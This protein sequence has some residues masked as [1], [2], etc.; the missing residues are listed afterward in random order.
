MDALIVGRT[1]AAHAAAWKLAESRR[2]G[3]L[4]CTSPYSGID[5]LCTFVGED[6][7]PWLKSHA[8]S[9]ILETEGETLFEADPVSS[10]N[11]IHIVVDC[12]SDGHTIVPL[13]AVRMYCD[14]NGTAFAAEAPADCFPDDLLHYAYHHFF[15]PHIR[16]GGHTHRGRAGILRFEM[17]V[18]AGKPVLLSAR[19]GMGALDAA[20]VLPL[21][22][23]ELAALLLACQAG[24]LTRE[25]VRLNGLA[26]SVLA[27]DAAQ[28]DV[29]IRG[30]GEVPSNVGVFM[31]TVR[32][33][34]GGMYTAGAH[35]LLVC[36]RS[37]TVKEA[38]NCAKAGASRIRFEGMIR[39]L[40]EELK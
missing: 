21:L 23:G 24:T 40:P 35:P 29:H 31:G 14:E 39:H 9:L 11:Q 32:F 22:R 16:T 2:I 27:L 36:S 6:P 34:D 20:A 25:M 1:A 13:P 26:M 3:A 33:K 28:K 38:R 5:T 17:G 10:D 19:S 8:P 7:E 18:S 30:L 4:Y 15:V 37:S 12:L